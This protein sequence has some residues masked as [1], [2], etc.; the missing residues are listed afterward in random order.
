M[1]ADDLRFQL[2][3]S[4]EADWDT[5]TLLPSGVARSVLDVDDDRELRRGIAAFRAADRA[6]GFARPRVR[7]AAEAALADVAASNDEPAHASQAFDLLGILAFSD[8]T[9]GTARDAG[10]AEPCGV[11]Q[12]R[13]PRSR[14]HR[15]EVQPRAACSACSRPRESGAGR[16]PRR[17]RGAAGGV[18]REPVRR[19]RA[20]DGYDQFDVPDPARRPARAGRRA[21]ARRAPVRRAT[22]RGCPCAASARATPPKARRGPRSPRS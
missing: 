17:A 2:S 18:A 11:R 5:S 16:T 15:G 8:S 13:P 19:G 10:R 14:E 1:R 21:A 22:G 9:S 4:S 7:G 12:R 20:I 3:A 6:R